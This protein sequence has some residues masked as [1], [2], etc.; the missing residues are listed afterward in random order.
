ML[1]LQQPLITTGGT[2]SWG[3]DNGVYIITFS[4]LPSGITPPFPINVSAFG[5]NCS[6]P[7]VTAGGSGGGGGGTGD[8][9]PGIIYGIVTDAANGNPIPS[10]LVSID[11]DTGLGLGTGIK[12]SRAL[13]ET[14]DR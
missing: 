3:L 9:T 14:W 11:F 8:T 7:T 13:K 1:N 2:G 6:A 5:G 4:N 10:A 12:G